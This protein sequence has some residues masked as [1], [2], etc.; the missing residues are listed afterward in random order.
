MAEL[1]LEGEAQLKRRRICGTLSFLGNGFGMGVWSI[2]IARVR[3]TV[4]ASEAEMGMALLVFAVAALAAMPIAAR[5]AGRFHI[6][7]I[8]GV[9]GLAFAC[10]LVLPGLAA[11][12]PML[13]LALLCLGIAH[14]SLDVVMNS[15]ASLVEG[16]YGRPIM[17]SFHAAWSVGGAIG[18]GT[19]GIL[20]GLGWTA[21]AILAVSAAVALGILLGAIGGQQPPVPPA[22]PAEPTRSG[23]AGMEWNPRL[24]GLCVIAF[25]ALFAEGAL[26]NWTSIYLQGVLT[27]LSGGFAAG[28]VAFS[29]GMSVGRIGGD[30][31][32][33]RLGRRR[34]GLIGALVSAAALSYVLWQPT[35]VSAGLCFV[36]I[37]LGMSNVV[38]ITFSTAGRTARSASRGIATAASAG[39]TGLLVGPALVGLLADWFTLDRALFALVVSMALIAAMASRVLER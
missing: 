18:A 7:R 34:V 9:F 33:G 19:A 17:S 30:R 36:V 4:G 27:G 8:C 1:A 22:R 2:E 23:W 15:R 10:A 11:S 37:G 14:G 29:A 25:C 24:I 26:A 35:L 6:N 32:V 39:Y 21:A 28:Y 20:T 3:A 5:L 38:P 13:C 12:V 16:D 31:V